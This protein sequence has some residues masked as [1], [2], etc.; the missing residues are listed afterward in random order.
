FE[1][2]PPLTGRQHGVDVKARKGG[3]NLF[4][5]SKGSQKNSASNNEVFTHGQIVNHIARQIHTLMK[6]A[7][8]TGE[9]NNIFV[10]SNPDIQRIKNE[11]HRVDKMV[12]KMG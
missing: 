8:E 2:D 5:E 3:V 10:L 6:Y 4:V 7:T 11:Y 9:Q 12:Q 1:C